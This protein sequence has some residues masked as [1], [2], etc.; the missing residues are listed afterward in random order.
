M[1]AGMRRVLMNLLAKMEE[2]AAKKGKKSK[3]GNLDNNLY[4]KYGCRSSQAKRR[5]MNRRVA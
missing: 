1:F 5:K 3:R 2:R 4:Y